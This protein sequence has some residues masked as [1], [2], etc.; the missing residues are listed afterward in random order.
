MT[1]EQNGPRVHF[2]NEQQA[3]LNE[4]L[5]KAFG[6]GFKKG[7]AELQGEIERLR[8]EIAELKEEKSFI[9]WRR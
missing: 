7:R 2:T 3:K 4:L 5:D 1:V 8:A 6:K 9:F